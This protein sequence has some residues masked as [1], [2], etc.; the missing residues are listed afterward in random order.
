[1]RIALCDDNLEEVSR[2]SSLLDTYSREK[3]LPLAW[4]T[5]SN[6]AGLLASL[7]NVAYDLLFLD[8][9]LPDMTGLLAARKIRE[10]HSEVKL[11]F[12]SSSPEYAA[13][14]HAYNPYAY[15]VKPVSREKLFSVLESIRAEK[16]KQFEGL[17]VNTPSGRID[18]TFSQLVFVEVTR[19]GVSL[20]L[21]DG[22]VLEALSF[23]KEQTQLP[24]EDLE[25][26]LLARP[27]FLIVHD[28]FI[29]N[30]EQVAELRAKD[31]ITLTGKALPISRRLYTQVRE[32]YIA[33]LFQD[34]RV[35]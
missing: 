18:V 31:L 34:K 29:V 3:A 17:T 24:I 13:E 12:L 1:M 27:E 9:L 25:K 26:E 22:S 2:I 35:Q 5:F 6:A 30:L 23:S 11:V 10:V 21:A 20:Q 4:D 16:Q 33:H 8:I 7:G 19:K 15:I 32:T 14:S 28:Q